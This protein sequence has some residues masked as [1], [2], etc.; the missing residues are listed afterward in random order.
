MF[1][2]SA[3]VLIHQISIRFGIQSGYLTRAEAVDLFS[4]LKKDDAG[5]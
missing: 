5:G 4:T 1:W 3:L 2:V